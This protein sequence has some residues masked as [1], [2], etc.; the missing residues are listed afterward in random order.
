MSIKWAFEMRK[1]VKMLLYYNK[2][3]YDFIVNFLIF[4][5]S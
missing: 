3:I 1:C 4:L 5:I 2:Q